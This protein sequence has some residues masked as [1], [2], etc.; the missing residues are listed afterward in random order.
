MT[1]DILVAA[2]AGAALVALL[3]LAA[4]LVQQ[5][6][7]ADVRRTLA[8]ADARLAA[9]RREVE[10]AT[11]LAVRAGERQRKAESATAQLADRLGQLELR[12][13]GRPYDQAI[14]LVQRGA[15]ADRLVRNFG[16]S[17]GEADLVALVHGRRAADRGVRPVTHGPAAPPRSDHA[18]AAR[19][20]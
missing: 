12:G 14:S 4:A 11:A 19:A 20:L 5:R 2:L 3:A 1:P 6:A 9:L 13:E 7:L 18:R 15:D 8:E 16:L 10:G 17:R